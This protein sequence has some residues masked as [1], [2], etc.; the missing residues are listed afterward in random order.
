MPVIQS[1]DRRIEKNVNT[2]KPRLY[3][4][5]RP[6]MSPSRPKKIA[7]THMAINITVVL[8][9][10]VNIGM[11]LEGAAGAG[12]PFAFSGAG[13]PAAPGTPGGGAGAKGAGLPEEPVPVLVAV[14]HAMVAGRYRAFFWTGL[15]LAALGLLTP[16]LGG[17]QA[18][19]VAMAALIGLALPE[20]SYV[21]AGQSVPLG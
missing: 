9:Y 18:V 15:G 14:A 13:G 3:I 5:T 2:A 19:A 8:L 7:L 4:L 17:W 1:S 6:I 20:H 16:W 10:A 12:P 21:Q 11:R